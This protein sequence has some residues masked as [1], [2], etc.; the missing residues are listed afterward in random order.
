MAKSPVYCIHIWTTHGPDVMRCQICTALWY[1]FKEP[2]PP[3]RIIGYVGTD[4]SN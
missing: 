3:Q 2:D 4:D 1:K